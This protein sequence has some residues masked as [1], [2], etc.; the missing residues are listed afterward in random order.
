MNSLHFIIGAFAAQSIAFP[1][2]GLV[3]ELDLNKV[4]NEPPASFLKVIVPPQDNIDEL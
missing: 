2:Y 1:K 3:M 4:L